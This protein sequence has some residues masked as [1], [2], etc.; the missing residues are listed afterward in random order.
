MAKTNAPRNSKRVVSPPARRF[1]GLS[2]LFLALLGALIYLPRLPQLSFRKDDWY[3]LYTAL[4][5]GPGAFL[6]L[7]LHTRPA[8]GPL[9][10]LL[11]SLFGL[12]PIPYHLSLFLWRLLGG[13][14]ALWLFSLLWPRQKQSNVFLAALFMIFPGFIWWPRAFEFQPYVLSLA[15]MVLSIVFTLKSLQS[16]SRLRKLAWIAGALIT[17]WSYLALV[18]YAI[19][20]EFFRLLCVYLFIRRSAPGSDLRAAIGQAL[21]AD[22][23]FWLIPLAFVGWYQ[24]LFE[25][26]RK[27]QVA[28]IQLGRVFESALTLPWWIVRTFQSTLNVDFL[29]WAVPFEQ[30]FFQLRLSD[31]LLALA[32]AAAAI[33]LS[34]AAAR[35]IGPMDPKESPT[36]TDETGVWHREA[37]WI[38]VLGTIGA[39][40]PIVLA[41]RHVEFGRYSH[42]ALPGSLAGVLVVGALAYSLSPR[43]LRLGFLSAL[44][45]MAG[46]THQALAAGAV[47]EERAIREFW[48]QVAWRAPSLSS[49]STLVVLYPGIDYADDPAPVWGP[50]NAIYFGGPQVGTPIRVNLSAV[51]M[52]PEAAYNIAMGSKDKD[53]TDL[54]ITNSTLTYHYKNVL[55]LTQPSSTSCVR[56]VDG[57]SPELSVD[58]GLLA[59]LTSSRSNIDIIATAGS[60]PKPPEA[61]FGTE[62]RHGWCYYYETAEL[63]RQ[64]G[65]LAEVARLGEEAEMAGYGPNDPI[66]WMPFLQAYAAL[67][68]TPKVKQLASQ[69]NTVPAY[70]L[71]AC[72]SLADLRAQGYRL[73]PEMFNLVNEAFCPGS[74]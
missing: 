62:P 22:A 30:S 27:A 71:Q 18:E 50:A 74:G 8:R 47:R 14:A 16:P 44:I 38:G 42:Y 11:F 65:N 34:V 68:K 17:G 35:F 69:I 6:D 54:I 20:M 43:G 23:V 21:R 36:E 37:L 59:L 5:G 52:T 15:L 3:F 57:D 19:G 4:V 26:W 60:A 10:E 63:A 9:Y 31:M 33:A 29:A 67:H 51:P 39:V 72:R 1:K 73:D 55:V 66:E 58:D 56:A 2:H 24:L 48:W 70:R 13:F 40:L 32:A 53:E 64:Q 49:E 46:L 25:N 41:N 45:G 61:L 7:T 12:Q 28:G